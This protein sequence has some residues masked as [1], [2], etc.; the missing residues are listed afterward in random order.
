MWRV[1]R[2]SPSQNMQLCHWERNSCDRDGVEETELRL[3]CEWRG[4]GEEEKEEGQKASEGGLD[5]PLWISLS[6]SHWRMKDLIV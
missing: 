6:S 4:D 3:G 1:G 5:G 2:E